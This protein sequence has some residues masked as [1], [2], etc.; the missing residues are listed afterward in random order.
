MSTKQKINNIFHNT[1]CLKKEYIKPSTDIF[2]D[3]GFPTPLEM[4]LV[5]EL[6]KT[7]EIRIKDKEWDFE[8][9]TIQEI[10]NFI[11]SKLNK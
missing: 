5:E 1:F 2:R 10:N 9:L 7:F 3:L 4:E 8:T 6:E 11:N